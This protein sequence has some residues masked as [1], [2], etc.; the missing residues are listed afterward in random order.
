MG[1]Y[2]MSGYTMGMVLKLDDTK[3][4][5]FK[6]W[7]DGVQLQYNEEYDLWRDHDKNT[8]PYTGVYATYRVKPQPPGE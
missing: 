7:L 3:R 2:D 4:Q 6:L 1:Y 8:I 5:V